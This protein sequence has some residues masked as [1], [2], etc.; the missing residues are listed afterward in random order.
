MIRPMKMDDVEAIAEIETLSFSVPWS[1]ESILQELDNKDA[2]YLVM[3]ENGKVLGYGGFWKIL[4]EAHITNLAITPEFR[5]RKL[6][7]K[8][9]EAMLNYC[10]TLEIKKATLEVRESNFVALKVYT[11]LGFYIEGK[12]SRYYT[13]PTEDAMIMWASL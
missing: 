1:K 4:D 5:G 8:L 9:L 11:S 13:N 6:G 7:K 10:R 3:E 2:Y 12:R